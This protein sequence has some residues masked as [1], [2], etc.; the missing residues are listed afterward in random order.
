MAVRVVASILNRSACFAR[1]L[2]PILTPDGLTT[3]E[4]QAV[5]RENGLFAASDATTLVCCTA[6]PSSA[7][8]MGYPK[9]AAD[10]MRRIVYLPVNRNSTQQ[11]LLQVEAAVARAC[12]LEPKVHVRFS[13]EWICD[14]LDKPIC[15]IQIRAESRS[16]H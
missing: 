3:S 7:R 15:G 9:T 10:V 14:G 4:F 13:Q 12:G 8:Y 1:R 5:L 16:Q 2:F 11:Q 6:S